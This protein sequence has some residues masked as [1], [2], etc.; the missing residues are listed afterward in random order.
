MMRYG[1]WSM[2][3]QLG[4][5]GVPT[6]FKEVLILGAMTLLT[7][8]VAVLGL[9]DIAAHRVIVTVLPLAYLPVIGLTIATTA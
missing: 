7:P 3:K 9:T 2:A 6:A 4:K 1:D 8:I 5:I